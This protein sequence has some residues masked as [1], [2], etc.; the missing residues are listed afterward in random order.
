[1]LAI[2]ALAVVAAGCGEGS[3]SSSP[4]SI[5]GVRRTIQALGP[6]LGALELA[7]TEG[8]CLPGQTAS[9]RKL[10]I[11]SAQ[12]LSASLGALASQIAMLKLS[13][14]AHAAQDSLAAGVLELVAEARQVVDRIQRARVSDFPRLAGELDVTNSYAVKRMQT[15][16]DQLRSQGYDLGTLGAN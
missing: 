2:S 9:A 11:T 4:G 15:A 7:H 6:V 5:D 10:Y 13:P 16:L 3:S 8:C 14:R 1:L 12:D